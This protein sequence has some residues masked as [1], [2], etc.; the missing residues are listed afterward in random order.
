LWNWTGFAASITEHLSDIEVDAAEVSPEQLTELEEAVASEIRAARRVTAR[1]VDA[2]EYERLPARSRGLP[3]GHTGSIRIV[4]IADVDLNT[5]GGTHCG[6]TSELEALKLLRTESARGGTRIFYAAGGRLRGLL[7]A[8]QD[9]NALLR[10]LLGVADEELVAGV[11]S[12]LRQLKDAHR[13]IRDLE[14]GLAV[15]C[16]EG[17]VGRTESV[18]F[19]HWPD[20]DLPFLQRVA[21]EM[22]RLAPERAVLLTCGAGDEGAFL[23]GAG[24]RSPVEVAVVGP[25]VAEVL[26]G[27]GGGSGRVFQGR[28][29]RLSRRGDAEAMFTE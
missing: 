11:E 17:L 13:V 21:K 25:Q 4:E 16:A 7:G 23:V 28:A 26:A 6:S 3:A 18:T 22:S 14:D 27:R 20:R 24:E 9:R 29:T 5:C 8:S 2:A 10:G 15:A 1:R 19:A 12:R